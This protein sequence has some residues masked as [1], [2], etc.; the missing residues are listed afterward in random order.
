MKPINFEDK[1]GYL[2]QDFKLKNSILSSLK[3]N[4]YP[5]FLEKNIC[6]LTEDSMLQLKEHNHLVT[7]NY[8]GKPYLL[9][10]IEL[11]HKKYCLF[12]DLN[13]DNIEFIMVK[14]RFNEELYKGTIFLGEFMK[15]ENNKS[16]FYIQNIYYYKG[17]LYNE[18]H[19]KKLNLIYNILTKEYLYDN[20]MNVCQLSI[21]P[22]FL[23]SH[24]KN[25]NNISKIKTLYFIPD[26]PEYPVLEYNLDKKQDEKHN[27]V[28]EKY[29]VFEMKKGDDVDI[30]EL[31]ENN[32][33]VGV[34]AVNSLKI[35]KFCRSLFNNRDKVMVKCKYNNDFNK[36]IPVNK[37]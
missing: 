6:E 11:N 22:Y 27:D 16:I 3:N 18:F 4:N 10:I 19:K 35:S 24:L 26:N 8:C 31:F 20:F 9:Y 28:I 25:V 32:K 36:W 29:K 7:T 5:K 34:A 14:F 2:I 33:Y 17:Q 1:K 30:Y 15:D 37:V 13:Q 21:K 12:C 23:Y